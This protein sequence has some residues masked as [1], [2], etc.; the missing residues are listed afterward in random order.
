MTKLLRKSLQDHENELEKLSDAPREF[1]EALASEIRA[2]C[3]KMAHL[4]HTLVDPK[5]NTVTLSLKGGK[6]VVKA[7]NAEAWTIDDAHLLNQDEMMSAV[8]R[9]LH[10]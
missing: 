10:S 7:F 8:L 4:R 9:F 2:Y 3:E 5:E 6:L 1:A